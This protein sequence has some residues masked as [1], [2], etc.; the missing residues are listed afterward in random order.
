M[1]RAA[2]VRAVRP[3]PASAAAR[4]AATPA[5]AVPAVEE[6]CWCHF[7]CRLLA[8]IMRALKRHAPL[9]R[10]R[11]PRRPARRWR[12]PA[13]RSPPCP[14]RRRGPRPPPSSPPGA[15]LG[16]PLHRPG[17]LPGSNPRSANSASIDAPRLG[18]AHPAAAVQR[19]AHQRLG[20]LVHRRRGPHQVPLVGGHGRPA[21]GHR[22]PAAVGAPGHVR[23][24]HVHG[25]VRVSHRP[26]GHRPG[27]P[28]HHRPAE[29]TGAGHRGRALAVAV[30]AAHPVGALALQPAEGA[31]TASV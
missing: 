10:P 8:D 16:H 4:T 28:V 14:S 18:E 27:R 23:Q 2:P 3:H 19:V 31:P 11:R 29:E 7:I 22:Q 15:L 20:Q 13:A 24:R 17:R 6:R 1:P 25:P 26:A 30:V 21:S 9:A 5:P 12:A